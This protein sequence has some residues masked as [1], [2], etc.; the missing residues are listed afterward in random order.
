VRRVPIVR[1]CFWKGQADAR[2]SI[3]QLW[4]HRNIIDEAAR[5]APPTAGQGRLCRGARAKFGGSGRA[6]I[7]GSAQA[8][9]AT[10]AISTS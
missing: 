1:S 4:F 3:E 9:A 10:P 2:R 8:T 7:P 6:P 5:R